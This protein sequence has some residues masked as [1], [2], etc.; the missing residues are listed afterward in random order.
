M[1]VGMPAP[2]FF[3]L[4][5]SHHYIK[6]WIYRE[7]KEQTSLDI[8]TCTSCMKAE[9]LTIVTVL[10]EEVRLQAYEISN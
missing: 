5:M 7:F 1:R 9:V 8:G 4:N 2:S 10:F 6:Q 3:L